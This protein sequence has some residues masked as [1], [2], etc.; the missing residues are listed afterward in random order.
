MGA[1]AD[2]QGGQHWGWEM[3]RPV[4]RE[5]VKPP[6]A[7]YEQG[8]PCFAPS[9]ATT[10]QRRPEGGQPTLAT[11][12]PDYKPGQETSRGKGVGGRISP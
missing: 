4:L 11:V 7:P 6:L 12:L 9:Q 10:E 5:T 8:A 1:A 3:L 2:R